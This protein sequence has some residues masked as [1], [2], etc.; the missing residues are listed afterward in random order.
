MLCIRLCQGLW[1]F[2]EKLPAEA[3]VTPLES[4]KIIIF[5]ASTSPHSILFP[6]TPCISLTAGPLHRMARSRGLMLAAQ[7]LG[8]APTCWRVAY[9]TAG[10]PSQPSLDLDPIFFAF[11]ASRSQAQFLFIRG[12]ISFFNAFFKCLTYQVSTTRPN[13]NLRAAILRQFENIRIKRHQGLFRRVTACD[14]SFGTMLHNV[15][16]NQTWFISMKL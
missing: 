12:H 4:K 3:P 10:V 5:S 14:A 7:R 8:P 1:I 13:C 6:P 9:S 15:V 2:P 11:I 16:F